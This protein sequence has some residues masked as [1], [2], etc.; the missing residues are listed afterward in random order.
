MMHLEILFL[1]YIQPEC[2]LALVDFCRSGSLPDWLIIS[3]A[4]CLSGFLPRW[5]LSSVAHCLRGPLPDHA[6]HWLLALMTCLSISLI[7][8]VASY[9]N[10]CLFQ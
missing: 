1:L 2:L 10:S 4:P 9:N 3:V 5:H 7:V 8:L 6:D